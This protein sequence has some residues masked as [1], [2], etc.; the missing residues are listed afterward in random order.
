MLNKKILGLL[1]FLFVVGFS[2]FSA[3]PHD[4]LV[5]DGVITDDLKS[6]FEKRLGEEKVIRKRAEHAIDVAKAESERLREL[7]AASRVD[8]AML[9]E[10]IVILREQ[11]A[12]SQAALAQLA[13]WI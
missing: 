1:T 3:L 10:K 8:A 9:G 5:Y 2:S 4:F 11:L 12:T 7:V 6:E 13:D